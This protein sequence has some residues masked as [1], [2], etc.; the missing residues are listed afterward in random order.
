MQPW[1]IAAFAGLTT[2]SAQAA[3]LDVTLH[4]VSAEGQGPS[5]GTLHI[6][7]SPYGLVF[8][9]KLHDLEPGVHGFH[10]HAQPSCEAAEKDGQ[11]SAAEAAGG[12]WDPKATGK[13]NKPWGNGHLGDLPALLVTADGNATQPVLAP[14]IKTLDEVRNL[15]VMVHAGGDNHA[16]H[17]KPLGGGG[18]RVACGVIR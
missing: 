16:D 10:L 12:H 7:Q 8:T 9:P 14:R 17:P 15:A 18:A 11:L 1:L 2:L 4:R 6:E 13:H 5:V 3:S